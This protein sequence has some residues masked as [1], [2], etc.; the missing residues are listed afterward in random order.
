MGS[1][2]SSHGWAARVA[3]AQFSASPNAAP[4]GPTTPVSY[5]HLFMSCRERIANL[6]LQENNLMQIVKLI[7]SDVL[8]DDQKLTIEIARVIRVGFLQQ[9]AFHAV[10]TYVPLEK[11]L[12]MMETILYLY[13]KCAALVAKQ[14]PVSRLL[15]TGLFDELVQ[16]KYTLSLI[17]IYADKAVGREDEL[18]PLLVAGVGVHVQGHSRQ[19]QNNADVDSHHQD[20]LLYTS[21]CV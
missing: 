4:S 19:H 6:L 14:V 18:A 10:D 9:N 16:M 5:T 21:R 8:P 11:Q 7:G 3:L 2:Y 1:R 17:H 12:K 13:D 15:A 20:C